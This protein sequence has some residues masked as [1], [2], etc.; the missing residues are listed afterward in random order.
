PFGSGGA[1]AVALE[2]LRRPGREAAL[3]L[4]VIRS[5]AVEGPARE[6]HERLDLPGVQRRPVAAVVPLSR[7]EGVLDVGRHALH[8][9]PGDVELAVLLHG[10]GCIA[11]N[12][13]ELEHFDRKR[14]DSVAVSGEEAHHGAGPPQREV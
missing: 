3:V 13:D 7:A 2:R 4:R 11:A 8:R 12:T 5:D 6:V 9:G 14:T 1:T 10:E